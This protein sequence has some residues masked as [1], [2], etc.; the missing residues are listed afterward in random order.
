[1]SAFQLASRLSV[2]PHPRRAPCGLAGRF[3]AILPPKLGV[4]VKVIIDA[5]HGAHEVVAVGAAR[6]VLGTGGE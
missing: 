3:P 4:K 2:Q 5:L 6:Q 1:M